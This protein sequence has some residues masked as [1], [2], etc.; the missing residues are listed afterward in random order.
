MKDNRE[1]IDGIYKKASQ[2]QEEVKMKQPFLFMRNMHRIPIA[3]TCCA[4]MLLGLLLLKKG[5]NLSVKPTEDVNQPQM[6]RR[7]MPMDQEEQMEAD[8]C[9]RIEQV[10]L[11]EMTCKVVNS[12][13][14][15]Y[16]AGDTVNINISSDNNFS[17][18]QQLIAKIYYQDETHAALVNQ[19]AVY[20]YE[21]TIN[22]VDI[23]ISSK[24]DKIEL[25]A[26]IEEMR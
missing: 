9:I 18:N 17:V 26:S 11:N 25:P 24:G 15:K 12:L 8:I 7:S 13:D 20:Y 1:F 10:N 2:Y 22:Q 19:A 23:Y 5:D 4:C 16:M 14:S 21:E 3:I 6:V